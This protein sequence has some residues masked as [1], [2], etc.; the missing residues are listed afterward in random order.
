MRGGGGEGEQRGL[1]DKA[2]E[3]AD[4]ADEVA[5]KAD[6]KADA[7][8]AKMR[9]W[10]GEARSLSQSGIKVPCLRTLI[11]S[12]GVILLWINEI[13]HLRNPGRMMHL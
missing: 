7:A 10:K 13:L 6:D 1:Q 8:A 11:S 5:N 2:D 9:Q 12:L 4:K 3:K